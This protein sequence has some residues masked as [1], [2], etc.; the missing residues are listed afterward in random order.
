M[1]DKARLHNNSHKNNKETYLAILL[2]AFGSLAS[3]AHIVSSTSC[4]HFLGGTGENVEPGLEGIWIFGSSFL[5][6]LVPTLLV[7]RDIVTVDAV[8]SLA[9]EFC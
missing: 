9:K 3:T 6:C 7:L 2:Q 4:S 5:D 8:A 1:N